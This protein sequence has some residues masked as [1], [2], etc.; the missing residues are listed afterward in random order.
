MQIRF[1]HSLLILQRRYICKRK[2]LE[3]LRLF[4]GHCDLIISIIISTD[5]HYNYLNT[6]ATYLM[7]DVDFIRKLNQGQLE[8]ITASKGHERP[9][10][11]MSGQSSKNVFF[12]Q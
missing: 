11:A 6:S 5:F 7:K 8:A 3:Q 1:I 12:L 9:M 10:K 4:Q 2:T